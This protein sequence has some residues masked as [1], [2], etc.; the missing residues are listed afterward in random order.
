MFMPTPSPLTLVASSS[1][2]DPVPADIRAIIDLFVTH[3]SKVA[4]PDVDAASLRKQADDLRAEAK[5]VARARDVLAAAIA[6]T[7]ARLAVLTESATRAIAYARIYGEA[8]PERQPILA[9]LAMLERP[10]A[11]ASTTTTKRRGRPPKQRDT[12]ELFDATPNEAHR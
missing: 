11:R 9:A 3:L 1:E 5:T 10:T 8:Q 7:D 6:A 12:A 4:F 2:P